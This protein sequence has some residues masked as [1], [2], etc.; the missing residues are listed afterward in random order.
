MIGITYSAPYMYTVMLQLGRLNK[1]W[2]R[3]AGWSLETPSE[4]KGP[5][6]SGMTSTASF[7]EEVV[8]SEE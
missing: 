3:D 1:F 2:T 7:K 6:L 5:D 8:K 4:V